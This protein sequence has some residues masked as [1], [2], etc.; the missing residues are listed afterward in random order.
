MIR[1]FRIKWYLV[2]W[3]WLQCK[4]AA[5][6]KSLKG[7]PSTFKAPSSTCS[8]HIPWS[9]T[10]PEVSRRGKTT[11]KTC[12]CQPWLFVVRRYLKINEVAHPTGQHFMV[13]GAW[14]VRLLI[15]VGVPSLTERRLDSPSPPIP[16]THTL[17]HNTPN[18]AP[19]KQRWFPEQPL[20]T[21]H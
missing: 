18:I 7:I 1:P 2:G 10:G 11:V 14:S 12:L 6:E 3:K 21:V 13:R 16:H 15:K 5:V 8:V 17:T 9:P 4:L 19:V 20:F